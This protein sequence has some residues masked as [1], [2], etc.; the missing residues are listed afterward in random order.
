MSSSPEVLFN[1]R[2]Y[3]QR[4][5]VLYTIRDRESDDDYDPDEDWTFEAW[6][7]PVADQEVQ[8]AY[9]ASLASPASLPKPKTTRVLPWSTNKAPAKAN[10]ELALLATLKP[11]ATNTVSEMSES[12]KRFPTLFGE[13]SHGKRKVW[14]IRVESRGSAGVIINEHGYEGGKMVVNERVVEKG[15]NLGKANET[16]PFQQAVSEAQSAWNKKRDAGYLPEGT[17]AAESSDSEPE[18]TGVGAKTTKVPLPMLA[19]DFNKRGKSIVFPCYVQAKLDGVR[20]VAV[21]DNKTLYSRN[22]KAFPHLEHIRAELAKLPAGTV[23]DGELYSDAL[24]FQ[25][26]VGLV[27]K[28]TLRGDDAAKL[29]KIYLCVYDLIVEDKTNTERNVL[30]EE[31]LDGEA[32]RFR[33]LK[34]LP[35]KKCATREEVKAYH[36]DFVAAGYE[37]LMLRNCTAKYRVG[38]RSTDLQKYKEFEDAEYAVVGYK[39]GDGLEKGCVIWM[40]ETAKGQSFAVRPRGTHE[41]RAALL[42]EAD[43]FVGQQLTVRF[44]ELTTDGIPRFPVGI[45]FRDYE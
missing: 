24:T 27:K 37:G 6:C 25:E 18:V 39:E 38:V 31:L 41:A 19:Q 17:D 20:C 11:Q 8:A 32:I 14:S 10:E 15:K 29:E 34:L 42:K 44:Q 33:H 23:L 35:T 16:T 43:R 12:E 36:A 28:E 7:G 13:S 5:G 3:L 30:L 45:A 9:T 22:G 1:G 2:K 4:A 26:I 21:A 40:C